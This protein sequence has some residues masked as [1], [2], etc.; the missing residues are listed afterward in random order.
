MDVLT[1][2]DLP[3]DARAALGKR[4]D[5]QQMGDQDQGVAGVVVR[6]EKDRTA[7]ADGAFRLS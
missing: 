7:C 6:P 1:L 5:P 2:G 3:E 4:R